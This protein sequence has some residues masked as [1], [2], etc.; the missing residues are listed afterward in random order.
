MLFKD[1]NVSEQ[2]TV[3]PEVPMWGVDIWFPIVLHHF[4]KAIDDRFVVDVKGDVFPDVSEAVPG[5]VQFCPEY[6]LDVPWE[7]STGSSKGLALFVEDYPGPSNSP[8]S[9]V[10]TSF[11]STPVTAGC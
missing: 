1:S 2:E 9:R 4:V 6:G 10:G 3:F 8:E 7:P 11:A 5:S